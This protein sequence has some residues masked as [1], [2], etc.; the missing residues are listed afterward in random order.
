M[1][2]RRPLSDAVQL[3]PRHLNELIVREYRRIPSSAKPLAIR[4]TKLLAMAYH[5]VHV[6][7]QNFDAF[8]GI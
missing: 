1:L 7:F 3:H 2:P 6:W 5:Q 4:S 8:G